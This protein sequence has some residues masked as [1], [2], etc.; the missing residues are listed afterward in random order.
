[1]TEAEIQPFCEKYKPNLG[2][3]NVKQKTILPRSATQGN[4]C[5][6]IHDNHFCVFRKINQ[7][8]YPDAKKELKDNFKN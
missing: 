3:Y 8:T 2:V 1:M 4:I 5:L 7:S 6:T